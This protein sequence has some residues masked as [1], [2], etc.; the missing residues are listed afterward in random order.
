MEHLVSEQWCQSISLIV[1]MPTNQK[2]SLKT[3]FFFFF[4]RPSCLSLLV[5]K[6]VLLIDKCSR[7]PIHCHTLFLILVQQRTVISFRMPHRM[8]ATNLGRHRHD[9]IWREYCSS[10]KKFRLLHEEANSMP[11]QAH[12]SSQSVQPLFSSHYKCKAV[13]VNHMASHSSWHS[14]S[15]GLKMCCCCHDKMSHNP[16]EI[17]VY[18]SSRA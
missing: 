13:Y 7:A 8:K 12:K 16:H 17:L 2:F 9:S 3:L 15:F 14:Q 4:P 6:W 11:C 5:C 18:S 10:S 1:I